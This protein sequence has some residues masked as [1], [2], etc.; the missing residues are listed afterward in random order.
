VALTG[1]L[2]WFLGQLFLPLAL[3]PLPVTLLFAA[4]ALPLKKDQPME[5]FL[6]AIM[7]YYL[8]P[9]VRK[10]DP[11]GTE[12]LVQIIAPKSIE[13]SLTKTLS[14]DEAQRRLGYLA[15]V[16]DS[17]GWAV[18]SQGPPEPGNSPLNSDVYY[19]AQQARDFLDDDTS[20]AQLVDKRLEE[21]ATKKRQQAIDLM[22]QPVQEAP[23]TPAPEKPVAPTP[24]SQ[25]TKIETPKFDPYPNSMHQSVLPNDDKKPI[26]SSS[27]EEPANPA[28]INIA[29]NASDL[30]VQT[31]S[32]QAKYAEGKSDQDE[33]VIVSLR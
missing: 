18:R 33:E 24:T 6:V 11:D 21:D 2:A 17:R 12:E 30:S 1:T 22:H 4:L 8:K 10:W 32:S 7:S 15:N 14:K 13:K 28:I 23:P 31:L 19:E 26:P 3:I 29:N 27:G 16:V 25:E 20:I 5:A 9:K